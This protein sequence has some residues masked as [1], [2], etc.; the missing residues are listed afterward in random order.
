MYPENAVPGSL[1][2]SGVKRWL[3]TVD[4]DLLHRSPWQP[5]SAFN[6][7]ELT[8]LAESLSKA[9]GNVATLIVMPRVQGGYWILAGERRWRAA[10]KVGIPS[11]LCM[12]GIFSEAQAQYIAVIDNIQRKDLNPIEEAEAYAALAS[13]PDGSMSLS[14]DD[15]ARD[16]GKS[17][18]HVS[19]YLRLLQLDMQVK[20][21]LRA[22]KLSAALARPLCSLKRQALQ[23]E[24]AHKAVRNDWTFKRISA[25]VAKHADKKV[26]AAIPQTDVDVKKLS[27]L[28][29]EITG[30]PCVIHKTDANN[31]QMG[32]LCIG[33]DGFAG[34]LERLGVNLEEA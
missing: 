30:H 28:V 31:W 8:E 27:E 2:I 11:L 9:G 25:E 34:L 32:F 6:D 13:G 7:E 20:D 19:N 16:V 26:A 5:R 10:Q 33:T 21:L 18:G 3:E 24:I 4:L 1:G 15:I 12:V 14:H 22:G 17:R 23:R 29:S